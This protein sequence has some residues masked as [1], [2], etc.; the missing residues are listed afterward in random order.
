MDRT[1]KM[2]QEDLPLTFQD[3]QRTSKGELGSRHCMCCLQAGST[4]GDA[5]HVWQ[6]PQPHTAAEFE[7]LGKQLN[8]LASVL[9]RGSGPW[10]TQRA[11]AFIPVAAAL[12]A[13]HY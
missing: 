5:I 1:A 4:V 13:L 12:P 6:A 9:V 8:M 11:L 2:M 3:L 7:I 10:F